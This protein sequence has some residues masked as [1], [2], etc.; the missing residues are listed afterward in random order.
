MNSTLPFIP[1]A[2]P[3]IQDQDIAEVVRVLK[4]GM[5]VQGAE[6]EQLEQTIASLIGVRNC[7]AVSNGTAT[8]HLCLIARGIGPGDEVI[9]P[10]FSYVATANVVELTG[11]KPV[12]VDIDMATFNIDVA[13]I[14]AAIS[15]RT[16]AIIPVHEF[17]LAADIGAIKAIAV[18][19]SLYI[20]EDAACALGAKE[21]NEF[22]GSFGAAGSFSLHPRKAI[23]TGEGGLITTN[24]DQLAIQ[25]RQLRNH[26]IQ[27]DHGKMDFVVAGY[28]YRM[29]NFQAALACSQLKRLQHII[30][31]KNELAEVYYNEI[32]NPLVTLPV[33]P[34]NKLH[35][36]QTF[37]LL[38]DD[39][40]DQF[41]VISQ[42]KENGIGTNY[43][44][45]CIPFQT[46]YAAKYQLSSA[47]LFPN[48]LKA[49]TNGL[50]IPIYEKMTKEDIKRVSHSINKISN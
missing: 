45:Q 11:A 46:F 20:I 10:A 13:K 49:F 6:V 3:D 48:A 36:W 33:V 14:E 8:M 47:A 44:A 28:N 42:L 31:Y 12:F 7:I 18:K 41:T 38:L 27:Y 30:T 17:G 43:G 15:P 26:G 32:K 9:V 39:S 37:H 23:T 2:S 22:V 40:I 16:K 35:S 5:L 21:C 29:T 4:S 34:N 50:A 1:L 25:L 19:H 24:D